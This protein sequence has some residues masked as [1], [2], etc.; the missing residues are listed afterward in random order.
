M[1]QGTHKIMFHDTR[2]LQN[3]YNDTI[4]TIVSLEQVLPSPYIA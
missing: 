2:Y 4:D 3:M 1:I